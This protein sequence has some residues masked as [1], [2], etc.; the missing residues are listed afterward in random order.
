MIDISFSDV[1]ALPEDLHQLHALE[2]LFLNMSKI[3]L[4]DEIDKLQRLPNLKEIQIAG[5]EI[6]PEALQRLKANKNLKV[7]HKE[8]DLNIEDTEDNTV[9]VQ[10]HN[11][12]MNFSNEED[13]DRFI[14]SIPIEL[15]NYVKKHKKSN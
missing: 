2:S 11:S 4:D 14:N 5:L 10:T 7:I 15:R 1:E 12:Y 13:A 3:K 6:N 9:G 8:A